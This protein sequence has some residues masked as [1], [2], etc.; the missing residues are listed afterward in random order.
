MNI[1]ETQSVSTSED[2]KCGIT[3][4]VVHNTKSLLNV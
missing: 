3:M 1:Q 2:K 4:H